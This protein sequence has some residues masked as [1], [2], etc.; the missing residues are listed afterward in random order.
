MIGKKWKLLACVAA[1]VA[2]SG[3]AEA[4]HTWQ[5]A[6]VVSRP[7]SA[8]HSLG[9]GTN[10]HWYKVNIGAQVS[11]GIQVEICPTTAWDPDLTVY[12]QVLGSTNN[13]LGPGTPK[14]SSANGSGSCD[15]VSASEVGDAAEGAWY[16]E[17]HR[18]SGSGSYTITIRN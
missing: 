16:I 18:F 17:V 12:F 9:T 14:G 5:T 10:D 1:L 11:D 4:T 8:T 7:Y 3:L 15:R 6:Q 2:I 13:A